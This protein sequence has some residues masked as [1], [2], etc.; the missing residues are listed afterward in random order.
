MNSITTT[1][2]LLLDYLPRSL[3]YM[4][5]LPYL[6]QITIQDFKELIH[7][8]NYK[9]EEKIGRFGPFESWQDC[10]TLINFEFCFPYEPVPSYTLEYLLDIY[11][12][13]CPNPLYRNNPITKWNR[14]QLPEIS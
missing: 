1:D 3:I 14:K 9:F 7:E 13:V 5:V 11:L 10:S 4:I 6:E 8:L 12:Y 2:Q